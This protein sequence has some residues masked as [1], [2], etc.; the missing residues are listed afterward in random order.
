MA[1][2]LKLE[3]VTPEKKILDEEVQSVVVPA[4]EGSL[5]IL[6]NHAPL[7]TSLLPG[8]VKYRQDGKQNILVVSG[9]FLELS[10][11]KVTILAD[12]A[13]RPEDID[14]ARAQAAKERA[15]ARL[16]KPT[17]DIDI[18]R[19]EMALQRALA[20]LQATDRAHR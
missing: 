15:E 16:K 1:K 10:N 8:H 9:G 17:P 2:I 5:G 6:P 4:P 20:R 12:S 11:N 13:E 7:I 19:A 14:R 3:V 18:L